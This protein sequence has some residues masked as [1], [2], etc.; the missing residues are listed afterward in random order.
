MKKLCWA[1]DGGEKV[2]AEE[3]KDMS[4]FFRDSNEDTSRT[5]RK[6]KALRR[7]S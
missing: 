6:L 7:K 2:E 4:G 3:R 1:E 5:N